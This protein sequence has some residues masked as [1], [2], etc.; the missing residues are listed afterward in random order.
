MIDRRRFIS[1]IAASAALARGTWSQALAGK[2]MLYASAGPELTQYDV[3][4]EGAALVKRESVTL[5]AGVQYAWPHASGRYLYVAS[6]NG[7]VGL[8]PRPVTGIT[9]ARFASTLRLVRRARTAIRLPCALDPSISARTSRRSFLRVAYN[10]PSGVTVHRIHPDGTPGAEVRQPSPIDAGTYAHQI[11]V[12]ASNRGAILVP[13]GNDAGP[14]R[15]RI[16]ARSK[17]STSTPDYSLEKC[18]LRRE[19]VTASDRG[20]SIFIRRSRGSTFHWSARISCG[21]TGSRETMSIPGR[22]SRRAR[23]SIRRTSDRDSS[24]ARSTCTRTADLSTA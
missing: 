16:P 19:A 10:N 1:L 13:R 14:A 21:C 23:W 6:S 18:R 3:D 9:P 12:T 20:T 5:P 17:C 7:G 15:P 11:R 22:S 24:R 2:V 4:V 8:G